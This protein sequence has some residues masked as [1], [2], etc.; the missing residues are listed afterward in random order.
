MKLARPRLS[1]YLGAALL[2]FGVLIGSPA[3]ASASDGYTCTGSPS[4]PGHLT[5]SHGDVTV[6][7]VCFVDQGAAIVRGDLKVLPNSG[8]AATFGL[9][10]LTGTGNSSLTVRGDVSVGSGGALLLG[11]V[12]NSFPCF[13][14]PNPGSPTLSSAGNVGG[15]LAAVTAD[16]V[17]VHNSTI[18]GDVKQRGGGAGLTCD[19]AGFFANFGSPAYSDYEDSTVRGSISISNMNGCWLGLA[20]DNIGGDLSILNNKFADPDAI[21]I[22]S[23]TIKGDLICRGN[24]MVWDSAD[25]SPTGDLW[26]RLPEPNTVRGERKG[27]CNTLANPSTQGGTPGP[28]P[29]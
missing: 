16:G 9:N 7:G 6:V 12:P 15:S 19:P 8:L 10:D 5:G 17:I 26:P 24:S 18:G 1:G 28:R 22:L 21:E 11:C 14:D 13:D 23:D 27:Q 3:A 20:R 4:S 2:A 29:F 25:L